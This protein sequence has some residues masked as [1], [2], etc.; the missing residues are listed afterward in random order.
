LVINKAYGLGRICE[1]D[2]KIIL[3]DFLKNISIKLKTPYLKT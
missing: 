2:E 1:L 3:A